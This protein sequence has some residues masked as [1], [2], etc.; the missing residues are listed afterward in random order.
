MKKA[1]RKL[2]LR[3][4]TVRDLAKLDLVRVLG[5]FQSSDNPCPLVVA[6]DTGD[7]ACVAQAVATMA[8]G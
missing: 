6:Y 2:V 7:H 4:E 5:G 1:S 3:S 8:C